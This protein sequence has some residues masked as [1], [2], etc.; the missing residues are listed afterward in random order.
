MEAPEQLAGELGVIAV[1]AERIV[2][3]GALGGPPGAEELLDVLCGH[4][5]RLGLDHEADRITQGLSQYQAGKLVAN[6]ATGVTSRPQCL[7]TRARARIRSA[8]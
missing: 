5:G 8:Q 7:Q 3:V 6:H 1:L 2:G 4:F